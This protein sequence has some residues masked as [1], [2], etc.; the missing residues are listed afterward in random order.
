MVTLTPQPPSREEG[1]AVGAVREPPSHREP[2]NQ[3]T[4][5]DCPLLLRFVPADQ[6]GLCVVVAV[7]A[8][9]AFERADRPGM[10]KIGVNRRW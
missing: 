7:G 5:R 4:A 6:G 3:R 9:G 10:G 8:L 2:G 1:G